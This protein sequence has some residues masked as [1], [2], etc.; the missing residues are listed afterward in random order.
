MNL[1]LTEAIHIPSKL[2]SQNIRKIRYLL[3]QVV[4]VLL[5]LIIM[6][7]SIFMGTESFQI[8]HRPSL[9]VFRTTRISFHPLQRSQ[10]RM[11]ISSQ[12]KQHLTQSQDLLFIWLTEVRMFW[13][14]LISITIQ[15]ILSKLSLLSHLINVEQA[16]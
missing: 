10:H 6:R 5:I 4:K 13:I 2:F 7:S 1:N 14:L 15:K 12:I 3:W 16:Q 9:W 11:D 8:V